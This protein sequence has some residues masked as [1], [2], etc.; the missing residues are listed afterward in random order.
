MIRARGYTLLEV[1]V[2]A[3]LMAMAMTLLLGTLARGSAQVRLA[4]ERSH[5][6]ILAASLLSAPALDAPLVP[7]RRAGSSADGR[8]RWRMDI[9]P[10]QDPHAGGGDSRA[11]LLLVGL[12]VSWGDGPGQQMEWRTLRLVADR[13]PPA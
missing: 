6:A 12:T 9:V 10:Y 1:L 13:E 4:G 8:Y 7:G 5:A 11:R 2:A 3:A